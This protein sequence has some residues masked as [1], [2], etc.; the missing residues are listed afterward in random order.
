MRTSL[1]SLVF[2]LT[3]SAVSGVQSLSADVNEGVRVER[4]VL[5][6]SVRGRPVHGVYFNRGVEPPVLVFAGIH[7]NEVNAL[8]LGKR[9]CSR[10]IRH[11]NVLKGACVLLIPVANPDG[12][13][14][15]TR[16]NARGVDLNRNF[17]AGWR[18]IK[19]GDYAFGG[20]RPLSEP[21][22]R[23]LASLVDE[24]KS[25]PYPSIR[26]PTAV[27]SIHNRLLRGGG[28]NNYD[29]PA[30]LLAK[31]MAAC[32]GYPVCREWHYPTPGS[33]GMFS[34]ELKQIPTVT[35]ELPLRID[36]EGEWK[37]NVAAVESVITRYPLSDER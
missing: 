5:G 29:G 22:A 35:L 1:W 33:F 36:T 8:K 10:W 24:T 14:R 11:P 34:G 26:P 18:H 12:V 9:L 21:E 32:N 15:G 20:T 17:S 4:V 30:E 3:L 23:I 28:V 37:A 13:A 27:I 16:H 6:F 25:C 31:R 7:G 19:R 2:L